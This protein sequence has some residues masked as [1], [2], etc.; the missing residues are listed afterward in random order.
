MNHKQAKLQVQA[1]IH[2]ALRKYSGGSYVMPPKDTINSDSYA[3]LHRLQSDQGVVALVLACNLSG[4]SA[5]DMDLYKLVRTYLH[6]QEARTQIN[7]IINRY[8]I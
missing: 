4:G 1:E 5:G 6:S 7:A 2:N 8:G 3:N